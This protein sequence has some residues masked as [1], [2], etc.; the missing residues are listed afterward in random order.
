MQWTLA[1]AWAPE[2][3]ANADLPEIGNEANCKVAFIYFMAEETDDG[4]HAHHERTNFVYS[5]VSS[6]PP[7]SRR[8]RILAPSRS[9][10][11]QQEELILYSSILY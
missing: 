11:F 1:A 8:I 5:C 7:H 4:Q 9:S 2:A 10:S 3:Q 6:P